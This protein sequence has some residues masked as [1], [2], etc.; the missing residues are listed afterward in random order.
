M[1]INN[2]LE[3]HCHDVLDA[4]ACLQEGVGQA[5]S[6]ERV[7][8]AGGQVLYWN[9]HRVMGVLAMSRAIGDHGLRPYVI[10]EPEVSVHACACCMVTM[11]RGIIT[12][13]PVGVA[14][15]VASFMV[16]AR[17]HVQAHDEQV[18]DAFLGGGSPAQRES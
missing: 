14:V 16:I 12:S 11:A 7:E 13:E 9:G 6:Q 15:A 1:Q 4:H 17:Q 2:D 3:L 8:K 18:E 5:D 10:P